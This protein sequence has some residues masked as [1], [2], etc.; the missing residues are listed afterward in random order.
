MFTIKY[1]SYQPA[2]KQPC[3]GYVDYT[4]REEVTGPYS[5]VTQD[6]DENDQLIINAANGDIRIMFGPWLPPEG[7]RTP[8]PTV[9]VMNESGATVAKYDL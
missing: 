5:H 9:W 1:R 6:V 2:S 3:D 4:S 7:D 8:R